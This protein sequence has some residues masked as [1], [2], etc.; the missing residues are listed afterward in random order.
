MAPP[1][2]WLVLLPESEQESARVT[3]RVASVAS[4]P[5][6]TPCPWWAVPAAAVLVVAV[7]PPSATSWAA[8]VAPDHSPTWW[9][10]VVALAVV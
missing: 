2:V 6:R 10:V 3:A 7:V 8:R 9:Y 4:H 5:A 1:L